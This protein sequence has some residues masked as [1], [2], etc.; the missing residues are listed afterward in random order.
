LIPSPGTGDWVR[1]VEDDRDAE[2]VEGVLHIRHVPSLGYA[3]VNVIADGQLRSVLPD[4]IEV[5]RA[6]AVSVTELEASDPLVH[7]DGWRRIVDLEHARSEGLLSPLVDRVGGTWDDLFDG[8]HERVLPLLNAG[9]ALTG[10]DRD[11]SWEYGDSVFCDLE[12]DGAI[13]NIEYYEHG[14]LV[15]YP[16]EEHAQD[17]EDPEPAAPFFSIDKSTPESSRLAFEEQGWLVSCRGSC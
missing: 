10:K 15:A 2:T 1:A 8:L 7:D 9:W 6:A 16:V 12:R 17:D 14:Q 4:S 13:L 11:E 3:Q 5:L